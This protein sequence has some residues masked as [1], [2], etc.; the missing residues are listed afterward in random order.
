MEKMSRVLE[1]MFEKAN[2]N[3]NTRAGDFQWAMQEYKRLKQ[4]EE[5]DSNDKQA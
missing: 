1:R 2:E 3:G 4:E 5:S